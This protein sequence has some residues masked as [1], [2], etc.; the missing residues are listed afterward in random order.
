MHIRKRNFIS[1][2]YVEIHLCSTVQ[3]DLLFGLVCLTVTITYPDVHVT[4]MLMKVDG[5]KVGQN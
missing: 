1:S 4:K 2:Y 3:R 5:K